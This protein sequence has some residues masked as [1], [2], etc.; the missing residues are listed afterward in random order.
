M[1]NSDTQKDPAMLSNT[2]RSCIAKS[3]TPQARDQV[4]CWEPTEVG[5]ET[6]VIDA[7]ERG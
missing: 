7:V 3:E 2:T 5:E 4:A 6:F 1:I